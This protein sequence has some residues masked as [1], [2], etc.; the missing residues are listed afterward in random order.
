MRLL[1]EIVL[2]RPFQGPLNGPDAASGLDCYGL[3]GREALARARVVE[4]EQKDF[5]NPS[6]RY[7]KF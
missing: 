1:D 4:G 2:P 5:I 6:Q 3:V 7:L